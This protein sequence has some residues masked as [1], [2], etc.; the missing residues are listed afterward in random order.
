MPPNWT[1]VRKPHSRLSIRWNWQGAHVFS[2]VSHQMQTSR[3]RLIWTWIVIIQHSLAGFHV[4]QI[5][6]AQY[7]WSTYSCWTKAVLMKAGR[8][9]TAMFSLSSTALCVLTDHSPGHAGLWCWQWRLWTWRSDH[10]ESKPSLDLRYLDLGKSFSYTS[11]FPSVKWK[12]K[13]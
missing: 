8:L 9:K 6:Q 12:G 5:H 2:S 3:H 7:S 4:Q 11:V 10:L 13:K 1:A